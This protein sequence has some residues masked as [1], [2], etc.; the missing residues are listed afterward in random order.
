MHPVNKNQPRPDDIKKQLQL[1]KFTGHLATADLIF[2]CEEVFFGIL[3]CV[4]A[5]D[6]V[7]FNNEVDDVDVIPHHDLFMITKSNIARF[8]G[9][10]FFD[11]HISR[12][13]QSIFSSPMNHPK[14]ACT[15]A[16]DRRCGCNM[17]LIESARSA[18]Q[19]SSLAIVLEDTLTAPVPNVK[20]FMM[21]S[22][23]N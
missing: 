13:G 16:S 21:G 1:D 9:V 22:S 19:M 12:G 11:N 17:M 20:T 23:L 14:N 15:C 18:D 7:V 10:D 6:E 5:L 2:V 8:F 4:A 3:R